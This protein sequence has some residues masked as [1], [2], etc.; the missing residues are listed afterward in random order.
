VARK[1]A[2]IAVVSAILLTLYPLAAPASPSNRSS[3]V[4]RVAGSIAPLAGIAQQVGGDYVNA[5]TLF[6]EG[7]DPHASQLPQDVVNAANAAD[8]LV[9]T[10]HF[11]WETDLIN[12]T[13]KPFVSLE[14]SSAIARYEDYGATL[15]AMPGTEEGN[16]TSQEEQNANPHGYWLLPR[17]AIAIANATRAALG[18]LNFTMSSIWNANF[19][20]FVGDVQGFEDLV[21]VRNSQYHF[22]SMRAIVVAAEEAYVAETFGIICD[23][24]LQV[25]N[26]FI[27][28]GELLTVQDALRNG[29]IQLILGSDVSRLETGGEFAY[30]LVQDYGGTLIWWNTVSFSGFA[31]YVA[32]MS[33]N[34]GVLV[35][36]LE[37]G[38]ASNSSGVTNL[39]L[40]MMSGLLSVVAIIETAVL[41]QRAKHE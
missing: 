14:D 17:N 10:G 3:N 25:E 40:I 5:S 6:P 28:P 4:L 15:S 37:H 18:M 34:L 20:G 30:Q 26:V 33:Y 9:L 1:R 27:S 12:Q 7:L 22:S 19:R 41:I 16:Q 24:V 38:A 23:A 29:T 8:L 39:V 36:A 21:A 11:P 13:G 31:D 32:M 35:S 2:V